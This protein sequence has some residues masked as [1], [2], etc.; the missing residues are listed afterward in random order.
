MLGRVFSLDLEKPRLPKI[1]LTRG[2]RESQLADSTNDS[3]SLIYPDMFLTLV[4][5][6]DAMVEYS[7]SLGIF[8]EAVN[9][10]MQ[11]TI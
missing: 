7:L 9:L 6:C 4:G 8:I 10:L 2:V 11:S 3:S 1:F 5:L